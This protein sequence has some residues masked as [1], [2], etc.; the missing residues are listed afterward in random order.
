MGEDSL[1]LQIKQ[2][3]RSFLP[4]VDCASLIPYSTI[5]ISPLIANSMIIETTILKFMY[6]LKV[7]TLKMPTFEAEVTFALRM[8][9]NFG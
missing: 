2:R 8:A 3:Y 5:T 1:Q 4:Q 9:L 6:H 7:Y